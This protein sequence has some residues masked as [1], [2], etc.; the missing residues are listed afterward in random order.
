MDVGYWIFYIVT[1]YVLCVTR[2]HMYLSLNWL[3]DFVNIPKSITPEELG[4]RL[5][6]HTV[7]IDGVEK[8]ADKFANIVV[9]KILEIKK[10]PDADKLSLVKLEIGNLK[11]AEVVCGAN[12]INVNDKVPV[13]L[14]GAKL[15]N[16]AEI[17]EVEVRGEK[18][19]GMLCAEDELG[20]GDDRR[21]IMILDKGAKIGQ[22]LGEYLKLKDVIFEVDNK[23]ITNRPDLWGH[24]GMAR[25]IAAFLGVR[26]KPH[27]PAPSP[28][29]EMGRT[30]NNLTSYL[31]GVGGGINVKVEDYKLCPRYMAVCLSGIKIEDSPKWMLERLIAVGMRPINNI[32]DI[33]NYVMLELGQPM[34]AFDV[35]TILGDEIPNNK[36]QITNPATSLRDNRAGKSQISNLKFQNDIKIVVRRAK[37]G[38]VLE[39][40]DGEKREL[41]NEMLVIADDK[42]PIALAGIMGG[43]NSEIR[44]ETNYIIIECANFDF[45]SIRKTSQK[46]GLRTES[47]MR[48]EKGLDP[49][50][51]ELALARA[52]GLI[53]KICPEAKIDGKLID[54]KKFSID[55][56]LIKLNL[57]W[58]NQ[59]V[60]EIIEEKKVI[61]ILENLGFETS[62]SSF[63]N[64]SADKQPSSRFKTGTGSSQGEGEKGKVL[65]VTIP[66]WRAGRDISI[67]ED[68]LEEVARIFGYNNLKPAMPMVGM[69]V[70]EFN[71]E[72]LFEREIKNI[73]SN[74]A[75]LSEVY[76]YSFVGEDQLT[77]LGVDFSSHIK[78]ANPIAV[79]QTL[80]R[81]NLAP[82][83]IN[84]I[85]TNQAK[86]E[87]FGFFEIGSVYLSTPG[88]INKG[89]RQ[90]NNLPYQEKRIGII[91]ASDKKQDVFSQ[92]KGAV[93][94]LLSSLNLPVD[95]TTIESGPGWADENIAADVNC[96]KS[97]IGIIAKLNEKSAK[98]FGVKKEAV[99]VE[100]TLSEIYKLAGKQAVKKYQEYEKYPPLIRDLAF[101]VSEKILYNNIRNEIINFSE[102]IR[103]AE[104]FDVYQGSKLGFG[105]KS[106]AFHI[107]YQAGRTLTAEEID[108]LQKQ[109]IQRLEEKFD[110]KIRDF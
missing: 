6:M 41:N 12:N 96:Q 2:K 84:N 64:V 49:N 1:R 8:Q 97:K 7:E 50:L 83:L 19:F 59:R 90:D 87:Q 109:L 60:G 101:V 99:I 102:L 86:F 66:S 28:K 43:A 44:D 77:K 56:G 27:P 55:Q 46:L 67:P 18:S 73:L 72:R 23:S 36:F 38:E 91:L 98:A 85:K 24:Y 33:T 20:L 65:E 75:G 14:V 34:H 82:N 80:L 74:G 54:E 71:Q 35:R 25:E 100:I 68:L 76:N 47:S 3:K 78:L 61:N 52:V 17:K 94:Y 95:F 16:G 58:L 32:V 53:K 45:A 42:K 5:T 4:L 22:S 51:C 31:G 79:H 62:P 107:I 26:L 9:G 69:I 108:V 13:A 110:A 89:D 88:E 29:Q 30:K 93:E 105:K 63:T 70:P 104:L 57:D 106:L 40:L 10:H 21:G 11:F 92:A 81:Q 103:S 48:F 15:P 37:K 39:S